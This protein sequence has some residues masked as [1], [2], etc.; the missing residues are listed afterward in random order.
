MALLP[1]IMDGVNRAGQEAGERIADQLPTVPTV[2]STTS[3]SS[4]TSTTSTTAPPPTNT[5]AVTIIGAPADTAGRAECGAASGTWTLAFVW[6]GDPPPGVAGYGVQ[7][8]VDGG[9]FVDATPGTWAEPSAAP[10]SLGVDADQT[11]EVVTE[12][13]AEDGAVLSSRAE[14]ILPPTACP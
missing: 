11:I 12:H 13:L 3:T 9:V 1:A 14:E 5:Q 4:T 10:V 7:W 2:A 8:R 6:P